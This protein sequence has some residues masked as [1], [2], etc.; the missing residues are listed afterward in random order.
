[1]C[2]ETKTEVK[3]SSF[4]MLQKQVMEGSQNGLIQDHTFQENTSLNK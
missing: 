3:E 2:E 1:M 4:C